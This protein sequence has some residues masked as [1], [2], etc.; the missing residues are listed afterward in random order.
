MW[1]HVENLPLIPSQVNRVSRRQFLKESD[2]IPLEFEDMKSNFQLKPD[3]ISSRNLDKTA[4][5]DRVEN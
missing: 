4:C 1:G 3:C 2:I 5:R